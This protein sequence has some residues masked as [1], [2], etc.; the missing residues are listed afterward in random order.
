M[1]NIKYI[2]LM[3]AAAAIVSCGKD[4]PANQILNDSGVPNL[5]GALLDALKPVGEQCGIDVDCK[6]GIA[7]GNASISGNASVDAFFQAVIDFQAKANGVSGGIEAQLDGIR[8]DFGIA[9]DADLSA[10]LKAQFAANL[11]GGISVKAE[12]AKCQVDA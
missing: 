9:G 7:Q 6:A 1:K 3:I 8:T 2:S 10:E 4:S 12:P 11:D 5:G